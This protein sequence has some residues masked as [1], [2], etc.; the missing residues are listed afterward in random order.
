VRVLGWA[1]L[2]SLARSEAV[3][4]FQTKMIF[5]FFFQTNSP[6]IPILNPKISFSKSDSKTKFVLNLLKGAKSKSQ[7][8][9]K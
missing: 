7:H 6:K 9:L 3:P 2:Q 5:L 8:I 1:D 4:I